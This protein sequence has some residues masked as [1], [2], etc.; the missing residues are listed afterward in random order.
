MMIPVTSTNVATKGADEVAGSN[1]MRF[2]NIGSIE[3]AN[4]P[5]N[6]TPNT[7]NAVTIAN[8]KVCVPYKCGSI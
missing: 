6:T 2:K 1:F 5:H 3:P 8:S 4:V 7:E